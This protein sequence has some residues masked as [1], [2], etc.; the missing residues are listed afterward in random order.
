MLSSGKGIT[1][2]EEV[3]SVVEKIMGKKKQASGGDRTRDPKTVTSPHH[4]TILSRDPRQSRV[5]SS[6]LKKRTKKKEERERHTFIASTLS[7]ATLYHF[8]GSRGSNLCRFA[9]FSKKLLLFS[10]SCQNSPLETISITLMIC[11]SLPS[12]SLSPL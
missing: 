8:L 1:A 4:T 7:I 3:T 11:Y 6:T 2:S 5:I 12:G 10:A 9:N